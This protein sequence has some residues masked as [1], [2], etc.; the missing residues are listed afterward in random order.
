M[1]LAVQTGSSEHG[2]STMMDCREDEDFFRT[3]TGGRA[4]LG[5]MLGF[6]TGL[7]ETGAAASQTRT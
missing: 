5:M 7:T 6:D 2:R 3:G 4:Q 1:Q